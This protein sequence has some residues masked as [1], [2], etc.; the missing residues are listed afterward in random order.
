M[1]QD[2]LLA[3]N[4]NNGS[5]TVASLKDD[6]SVQIASVIDSPNSPDTYRYKFNAPS[7][8]SLRLVED[9]GAELTGDDG[10]ILL[11]IYALVA[12]MRTERP[13]KLATKATG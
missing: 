12:G 13:L 11:H 1:L 4:N 10:E 5:S 6:T 7:G 2:G 9:G 3:Y 8:S